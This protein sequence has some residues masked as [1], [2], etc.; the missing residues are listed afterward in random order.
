MFVLFYTCVEASF[1]DFEEQRFFI[2]IFFIQSKEI[3]NA[4]NVLSLIHI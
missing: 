3:Y 4:M 1:V 2:N